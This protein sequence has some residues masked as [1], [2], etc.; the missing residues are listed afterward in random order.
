MKSSAQDYA[1]GVDPS[2][3]PMIS[4]A[5]TEALNQEVYEL[6]EQLKKAIDFSEE[7]ATKRK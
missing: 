5:K 2:G 3:A 7:Q 1:P 6:R 4:I